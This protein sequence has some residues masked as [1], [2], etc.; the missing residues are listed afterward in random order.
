MS[1]LHTTTSKF[2][3]LVLRHQ[4]ET[5]GVTLDPEGWIAIDELL[6]AAAAH[7]TPITRG[8]LDEVVA[9]SDKQRFAISADG[10]RIR[11]NQGHSVEVDLKLSLV[12][13][14][15]ELFHG[16][17]A[18]FL[19]SIRLSGLIKGARQHVHLSAD[20]ITA[21]KVGQRRGQPVILGV[22]AGRMQ[23]DGHHF[24]RSENGVWLVDAVP[25][26]Y[27]AFEE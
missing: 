7:G 1:K 23:R 10:A 22:A 3:S 17:V 14:L 2:L 5:I 18:K 25:A 4:P 27:L 6:I 9:S 8:L 26:E 24:Y 15:E 13:P 16:T 12:E 20:R 21:E 11:A 19:D